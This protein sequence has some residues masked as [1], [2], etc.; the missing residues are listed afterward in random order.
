MSWG[1]ILQI[2]IGILGLG[3]IPYLYKRWEKKVLKD[4]E[5][6]LT[7]EFENIIK[8]LSSD[9]KEEKMAAAI[10]LRKFFDTKS[11]FGKNDRPF[12]NDVINTISSILRV[13]NTNHFQKVLADSLRYANSLKN[14]DLQYTNLTNAFLGREKL[15]FSGADFFRANLSNATFKVKNGEGVNLNNAQFYEAILN[16]T[17]FANC[18]LKKANFYGAKLINTKFQNGCDLDGANFYGCEINNITI[19]ESCKNIPA[20]FKKYVKKQ[21]L[22]KQKSV[23]LSHPRIKNKL[24]Q[25]IFDHVL[26]QLTEMGINPVF[27]DRTEDQNNGILERINLKIKNCDGIIVFNFKQLHIKEGTYRWWKSD[28]KKEIKDLYLS[29]PWILL[30]TGMAFNHNLKVFIISEI[31]NSLDFFS[32]ISCENSFFINKLESETFIDLNYKLK[33]WI[34]SL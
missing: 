19:D 25:I 27:I 29:T 6:N 11:T 23:F 18:S 31:S 16:G 33:K 5:R 21:N 20:E 26:E 32:Q 24:Q 10:I 8:Q 17:I 4:D 30:E 15:D 3:F 28:E 22:S 2:V 12:E 7:K 13:E 1:D 9:K 14:A 34:K